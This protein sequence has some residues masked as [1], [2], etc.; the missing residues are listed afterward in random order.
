[1]GVLTRKPALRSSD[2]RRQFCEALQA[3]AGDQLR[4][5]TIVALA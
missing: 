5:I 4:W 3:E 2:R 1:M